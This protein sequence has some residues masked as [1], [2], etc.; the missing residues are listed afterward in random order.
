M[1]GALRDLLLAG[2]SGRRCEGTERRR[3][4]GGAQ[5]RDRGAW[6]VTRRDLEG[7]QEARQTDQH[8]LHRLYWITGVPNQT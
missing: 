2:P 6:F 5:R 8:S 1:Q 7:R 3:A 4:D